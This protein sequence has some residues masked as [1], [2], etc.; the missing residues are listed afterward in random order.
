[1]TTVDKRPVYMSTY[2][3]DLIKIESDTYSIR[4]QIRVIKT[5]ILLTVILY[6][7][8]LTWVYYILAI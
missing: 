7:S 5:I 4:K 3:K 1:M 2:K 8:L 6:V